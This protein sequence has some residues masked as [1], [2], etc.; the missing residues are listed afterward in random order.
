MVVQKMQASSDRD[1]GGPARRFGCVDPADLPARP[2]EFV[3]KGPDR[4]GLRLPRSRRVTLVTFTINPRH[5]ARKCVP[6]PLGAARSN[7]SPA[8]AT[9][10]L[11]RPCSRTTRARHGDGRARRRQR[12][13]GGSSQAAAHRQ[14]AAGAQVFLVSPHAWSIAHHPQVRVFRTLADAVTAIVAADAGERAR[15]A[16]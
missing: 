5:G 8:L 16:T 11:R 14:G 7:C 9:A 10:A 12:A 1:V 4:L 13:H 6:P 2:P 15:R 3:L